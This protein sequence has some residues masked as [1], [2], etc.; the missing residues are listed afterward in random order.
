MNIII[1]VQGKYMVLITNT[2]YYMQLTCKAKFNVL[3]L[4]ALWF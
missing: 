2:V 1:P 3:Y 4:S